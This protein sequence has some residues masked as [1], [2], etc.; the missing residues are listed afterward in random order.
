MIILCFFPMSSYTA[1][2]GEWSDWSE[3]PVTA[4]DTV[5]VE[6]K[7]QYRKSTRTA[8]W[9]KSESGNIDYAP[10]WTGGFNKSHSLYT[11]YNK[12]PKTAGETASQKTTVT[13]TNIGWIYY[14]WCMGATLEKTYNRTIES[15]KTNTHKTFHAFY[16]TTNLA[17]TESA[18]A[19]KKDYYSL[20]K[21]TYWWLNERITIKRCA[22]IIYN[23]VYGSWSSW[24][25]WQD[26][27][28]TSNDTNTMKVQTRTVYR[29]RTMISP[30]PGGDSTDDTSGSSG[31]SKTTATGNKSTTKTT[32]KKAAL[33]K[34]GKILSIKSPKAKTITLKWKKLSGISGYQCYLSL[35]KDFSMYT[36]QR[37]YNKKK[38][39]ATINNL[40][41]K[42]TYYVK[43][44]PFKKKNG[45]KIYGIWSPVKKVKIK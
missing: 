37:P 10:S 45:K 18:N 19:R 11:K 13:T 31:T 20:C 9:E 21:D 14:H 28:I 36:V 43:I 29:S 15:Y 17:L 16:S 1:S 22:Y 8:S 23:K 42:K 32:S 41:S 35:K 25:S 38:T 40:R 6:K 26:S 2:W 12:T 33:N 7:T 27:K 39:K 24:S 34:K 3:T 44:R 30:S 4:S 5:Q